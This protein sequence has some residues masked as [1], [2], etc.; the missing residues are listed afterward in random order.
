MKGVK[1][2]ERFQVFAREQWLPPEELEQIRLERLKRLLTRA[3]TFSPFYK[4]RL[5]PHKQRIEH[6]TTLDELSALPLL[7]RDDL[8]QHAES[9]LCEDA[10]DV[11]PD[12]SG[13]STGNPVNF[14]HSREYREFGGGLHLLFLSWL[15]VRS[16]DPT[17]VFW[18]ADRDF[19][20]YSRRERLM[21]RLA[22][23]KLLNSFDIDD[24]TM[25]A[26]LDELVAFQ[27]VYIYGYAS[28]LHQAAT[29]ILT[30]PE[31]WPIRPLAIR[32]SAEM[33]YPHQREAIEQAFKAPV[34]NFYGSREINNLAAECPHRQGLHVM[35][36]GRVI[37]IVDQSG[38]AL[39]SGETGYIAVTDLS[40]TAFPF[41]RYLIGDM[42][43]LSE[44]PCT[45]GR[46]YPLLRKVVGR[47]SDII[48]VGGKQ[49]HGEFFTHLFY[50]HPEIKQFQVVQ[51]AA[52]RLIVKIV[53]DRENPDLTFVTR[54]IHARTGEDVAVAIE[55]VDAIETT[56]S[57]KYR[58]TVNRM[59]TRSGEHS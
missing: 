24:S 26:F 20:D 37:E 22:R 46:A 35:A 31:R 44:E 29:R 36:S 56:A 17:A 30:D 42:G 41:I 53:S 27:P 15:G 50:G 9:I 54:G 25:D 8:Q 33:L 48:T 5:A 58:F 21:Q 6:M 49:I 55:R 7:T 2:W 4:E 11:Q 18:G 3:S 39:P 28:S 40:E 43:S 13:G 16:G 38:T 23:V 59:T 14:Y 1:D 32:S 52:D 19:K 10:T 45:C 57:G 34:V 12:A 51:V 47:S